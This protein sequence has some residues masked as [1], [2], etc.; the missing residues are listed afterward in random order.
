M[1]TDTGAIGGP[2]FVPGFVYLAG[3][4]I[5]QWKKVGPG[6]YKVFFFNDATQMGADNTQPTIPFTVAGWAPVYGD[7]TLS[8]DGQTIIGNNLVATIVPPTNPKFL[9]LSGGVSFT[10]SAKGYRITF[11]TFGQ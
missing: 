11:R 8:K 5:G 3:P 7:F 10:G 4:T 2:A 9:N 6:K 1:T